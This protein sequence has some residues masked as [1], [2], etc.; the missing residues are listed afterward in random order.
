M[1]GGGFG[2]DRVGRVDPRR[3]PVRRCDDARGARDERGHV[4]RLRRRL[5]DHDVPQPRV[6]CCA[7]QARPAPV[8]DARRRA[9]RHGLVPPVRDDR[10]AARRRW[11]GRR[12]PHL[13]A[14]PRSG[15]S[16]AAATASSSRRSTLPTSS[17]T[18]AC[19]ARCSGAYNVASCAFLVLNARVRVRRFFGA[20]GAYQAAVVLV[21]AAVF[22][23]A[24]YES[25]E[26][27]RACARGGGR[28]RARG[29][30][31]DCATC[32]RR[33]RPRRA[34]ATRTARAARARR[35]ALR[36]PRFWWFALAFA[37][38][39]RRRGG[40]AL[41]GVFGASPRAARTCAGATRRSGT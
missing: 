2:R 3:R 9:R 6:V 20:L 10:R 26:P 39:S 23:P 36:E 14:W 19:A 21:V 27:C 35:G 8:R 38:S 11:R 33:R 7:R 5:P 4:D 25:R 28:A 18:V 31:R 22:P 12:R 34:R 24:P 13:R 37:W 15:S 40:G 17:T 30:A 1:D 32:A 41:F 29:R 16:A